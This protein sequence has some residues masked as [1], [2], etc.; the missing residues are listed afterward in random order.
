MGRNLGTFYDNDIAMMEHELLSA[1]DIADWKP[2]DV[3]LYI[4][5]VHDMAQ[6][7]ILKIRGEEE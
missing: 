1:N 7:I 4:M 2:E 5:G 6:K 3:Q